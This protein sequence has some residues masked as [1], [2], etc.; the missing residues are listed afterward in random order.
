MRYFVAVLL[1]SL[2]SLPSLFAQTGAEIRGTTLDGHT[3]QP[4]ANVD[5]LLDGQ[6]YKTRSDA[7]GHFTI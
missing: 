6:S 1:G 2:I 7:T 5:V 3:G 4:L